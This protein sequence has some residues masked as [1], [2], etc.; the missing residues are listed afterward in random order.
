MLRTPEYG[1]EQ[2]QLFFIHIGVV[3]YGT[4]CKTLFQRGVYRLEH[5]QANLSSMTDGVF[6]AVSTHTEFIC[7]A[8]TPEPCTVTADSELDEGY[9]RLPPLDED[10]YSEE[11]DN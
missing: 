2:E 4:D 6:T 3:S 1:L 11:Y 9:T 8:I 7:K 5:Q 10:D